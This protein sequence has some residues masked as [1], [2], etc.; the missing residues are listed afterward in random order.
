MQGNGQKP[1]FQGEDD[2]CVSFP[3][4]GEF[5]CKPSADDFR[6]PTPG[7]GILAVGYSLLSC[8]TP[9]PKEKVFVLTSVMDVD[10]TRWIPD[11]FTVQ[12]TRIDQR[13]S[14]ESESVV[15]SDI[16]K[17]HRWS[18]GGKVGMSVGSF[19]ASVES[20]FH[21]ES[22]SKDY[23]QASFKSFETKI[24]NIQ[25]TF[26]MRDGD[27]P[28][29]SQ[30]F[31]RKVDALYTK[32]YDRYFVPLTGELHANLSRGLQLNLEEKA[33]VMNLVSTFGF[34]IKYCQLGSQFT[35][36]RIINSTVLKN[37]ESS[38][39]GFDVTASVHALAVDASANYGQSQSEESANE[40]IDKNSKAFRF[41]VGEHLHFD[42]ANM[43]TSKVPGLLTA[44][45][46]SICDLLRSTPQQSERLF[47]ELRK[48]CHKI[49]GG[50]EYCFSELEQFQSESVE[51]I[52]K[53]FAQIRSF[54]HCNMVSPPF[55]NVKWDPSFES[56]WVQAR[57][58]RTVAGCAR[59][60]S[61][62]NHCEGWLVKNGRCFTCSV[63]ERSQLKIS[64]LNR[65]ECSYR[66]SMY[67][68]A[69]FTMSYESDRSEKRSCV[70]DVQRDENAGCREFT[71]CAKGE[72][73]VGGMLEK[74]TR[75]K[76]HAKRLRD[77]IALPRGVIVVGQVLQEETFI[78]RLAPS[79]HT[80]Q[81]ILAASA[82]FRGMWD[83]MNATHFTNFDMAYW[84]AIPTRSLG[85]VLLRK[86]V[87]TGEE[88]CRELCSRDQDCQ[89]YQMWVVASDGHWLSSLEKY[90]IAW[91]FPPAIELRAFDAVAGY[92]SF[93]PFPVHVGCRT[94]SK[95]SV[96]YL[97][98]M[99]TDDCNIDA[100]S[101][102]FPDSL[103]IDM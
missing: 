88:K 69:T 8:D 100:T 44:E 101:C 68:N 15:S 21:R 6:E 39:S 24:T 13:T 45:F 55:F 19:G 46:V 29:L 14:T 81:A 65:A 83:L 59:K 64:F 76:T 94:F 9:R 7:I 74:W 23:R 42:G 20:S 61:R 77:G 53:N 49:H 54:R 40:Q 52:K 71:R 37:L 28:R 95:D 99:E 57:T 36:T 91:A 72:T 103:L 89:F 5:T 2:H 22:T 102:Q 38:R 17:T 80:V 12:N 67:T 43:V 63:P 4:Q 50:K 75:Q 93:I 58:E 82:T 87:F 25:N 33:D 60:C 16:T 18:A 66:A 26:V 79:Q 3:M 1:V 62:Q 97:K 27:R 84:R 98:A 51:S 92:T 34:F 90:V 47:S 70:I 78:H 32:V 56:F 10:C 85:K 48:E 35:E 86:S 41:E 30:Q 73:C 31:L 96:Y 11:G